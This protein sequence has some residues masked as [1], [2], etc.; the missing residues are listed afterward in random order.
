MIMGKE[1][2][3]QVLAQLKIV[4]VQVINVKKPYT[5]HVKGRG[6]LVKLPALESHSAR[7]TRVRT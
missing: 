2:Y 3:I 6:A 5:V 1:D 4:F 7:M